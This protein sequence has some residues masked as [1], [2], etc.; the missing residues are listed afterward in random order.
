MWGSSVNWPRQQRATHSAAWSDMCT[1]NQSR[2]W[3]GSE[4]S[5]PPGE[6]GLVYEWAL[7]PMF[8]FKWKLE[9]N[10]LAW[11]RRHRRGQ[12]AFHALLIFSLGWMKLNITTNFITGYCGQ[13]PLKCFVIKSRLTNPLIP[14]WNRI[15]MHLPVEEIIEC[16]ND[17]SIL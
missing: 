12:K 7:A 15:Y 1:G 13:I 3:R 4:P 17:I 16:S 6:L 2:S 10:A 11:Q 5:C 8:W 9:F 14:K